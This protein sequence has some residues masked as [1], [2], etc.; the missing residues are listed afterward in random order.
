MIFQRIAGRDKPGHDRRVRAPGSDAVAAVFGD[1]G[2][3]IGREDHHG[4]ALEAHPLLVFQ[5]PQL[6]VGA[7]ARH[8][9]DV[10]EVLLGD[11]NPALVR[12]SNSLKSLEK[13]SR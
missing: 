6:L 13:K 10:A 12:A 3:R 2:E 7:L 5:Q 11:R 9:D 4:V 1:G 8:P